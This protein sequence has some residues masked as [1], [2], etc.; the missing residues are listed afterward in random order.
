[1]QSK[2]PPNP[3]VVVVIPFPIYPRRVVILAELAKEL[4]F[5]AWKERMTKTNG[6]TEP[7]GDTH[8][9]DLE[10]VDQLP[11]AEQK[12]WVLSR[13]FEVLKQANSEDLQRLKEILAK[14]KPPTDPCA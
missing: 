13:V 2:E 14:R 9:K 7:N 12:L 10:E 5:L 1:M 8:D 4:D 11:E 3:D 6:G